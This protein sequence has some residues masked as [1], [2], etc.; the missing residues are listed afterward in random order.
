MG[1]LNLFGVSTGPDKCY[2]VKQAIHLSDN[3]LGSLTVCGT[4]SLKQS[5]IRQSVR[6]FVC[7][8]HRSTAATA[9]GGFA[10]K[11]PMGR[12][13]LSTGAGSWEQ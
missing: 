4:G 8:S 3:H 9:T 1:Y 7:Q 10:A 11:Q 5:S 6:P 13:Y 2:P 12:R